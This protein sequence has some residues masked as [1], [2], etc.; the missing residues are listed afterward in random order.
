MAHA[1][2]QEYCGA[3]EDCPEVKAG[4]GDSFFIGARGIKRAGYVVSSA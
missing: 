3:G 2:R 4:H 1:G